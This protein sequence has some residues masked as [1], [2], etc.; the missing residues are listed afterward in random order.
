MSGYPAHTLPLVYLSS[1]LKVISCRNLLL[2]DSFCGENNF[3]LSNNNECVFSQGDKSANTTTAHTLRFPVS[4]HSFRKLGIINVFGRICQRNC[5]LDQVYWQVSVIAAAMA[6]S[7]VVSVHPSQKVSFS[8]MQ[9]FR[10]KVFWTQ[11]LI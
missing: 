3:Q 10:N 2:D 5:F 4:T 7:S 9:F 6:E 1:S 8:W 11:T